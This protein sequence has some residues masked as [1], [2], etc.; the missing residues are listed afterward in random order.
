MRKLIVFLGV[1]IISAYASA[2]NLLAADSGSSFQMLKEKFI[3]G[4]WRFMSTILISMIIG[5]ALSIERVITLNLA[6][7]NV[8]KLLKKVDD[9]CR[10]ICFV[11]L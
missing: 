5:L 9:K 4:D 8:D 3:E 1:F 7:I 10:V 2:I 11:T 6:S